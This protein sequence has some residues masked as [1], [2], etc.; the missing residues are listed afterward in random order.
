MPGN[1]ELRVVFTGHTGL[2][3]RTVLLR[4]AKHIYAQDKDWCEAGELTNPEIQKKRGNE[5]VGIYGAEDKI[6]TDTFLQLTERDQQRVWRGSIL[7][8]MSSWKSADPKPK[9]AFLSLHLTF[10]VSSLF[11]SPMAWKIPGG[12]HPP[13]PKNV[14]INCLQEFDPHYFVTLIDDVH[15]VQKR[16]RKKQFEF[17]LI[18]LLRW[19][20][21][22]TLMTDILAQLVIGKGN[23]P[24]DSE[25]YPFERSPVVAVRHPTDMLLKFLSKPELP[26][27]YASYPISNPRQIAADTGSMDSIDEINRFRK[28]LHDRYTVFDPVTIDEKPLQFLLKQHGPA[29]GDELTLTADK[30][31]PMQ[32]NDSLVGE[33]SADVSGLLG[34]DLKEIGTEVGEQG[35]EIDRQI[36]Q[37]DFR[38]IDQADCV[39]IYRPTYRKK[40]W[41]TGTYHEMLYAHD[42]A[43][44][45][46]FVIRDPEADGSLN[47]PP[48]QVNMPKRNIFDDVAG[49][50]NPANQQIV[51]EKVCEEIDKI[52]DQFTKNR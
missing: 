50:D 4:L 47:K 14:L 10:Q 12:E 30:W 48:F 3:K 28:F 19:R 43:K 1:D 24:E 20:N 46:V 23:R 31:W 21:V 6:D 25:K 17:R 15:I 32:D 36:R 41:S 33:E 37:R 39:V 7:D 11:F 29:D 27:I 34:F 13:A 35:S 38:L 51:L 5:L 42:D 45:R 8:A 40:L 18:E 22:E 26:R 16:I 49:L 2:R 44:K 9:Y 52:A